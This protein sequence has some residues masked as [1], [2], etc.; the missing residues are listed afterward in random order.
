M[1]IDTILSLSILKCVKIVHEVFAFVKYVHY[2]YLSC[3]CNTCVWNLF[4]RVRKLVH[5]PESAKIPYSQNA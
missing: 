2:M 1:L 5:L 4:C 3:A